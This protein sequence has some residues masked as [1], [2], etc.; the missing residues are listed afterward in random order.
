MRYEL[1]DHEWIA[2]KLL[3]RTIWS[4]CS[5]SSMAST[6]SS[7]SMLPLTLRRPLA[8]MNSLVNLVTTV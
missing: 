4:I 7:I 6:A 1:A 5:A 2:I 8:S 3:N